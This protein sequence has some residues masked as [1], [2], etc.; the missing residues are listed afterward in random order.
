M[1]PG[2]RSVFTAISPEPSLPALSFF[3]SRS[4]SF[5][6]I[7]ALGRLVK[8]S[9]NRILDFG[10]AMIEILETKTGGHGY[11]AAA[12]TVWGIEVLLT[13]RPDEMAFLGGM[14]CFPGGTVQE[15]D[16]SAALSPPVSWPLPYC[17]PKDHWLAFQ[18]SGGSGT[19]GCRDPRAI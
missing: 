2:K 5:K 9:F 15:E 6:R 19:L 7:T 12:G 3:R 11:P 13:R 16:L 4:G 18:P 8:I 17:R 1:I 10:C 14:Y